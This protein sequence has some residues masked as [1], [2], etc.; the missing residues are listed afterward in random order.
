[1]PPSPLLSRARQTLSQAVVRYSTAAQGSA[2]PHQAAV[3]QGLGQLQSLSAKLESR[4][5]RVAVFGL[6]S[7]GKSAVINAL[8][9]ESILETGPLHGVT[10]WPRSV[11]WQPEVDSDLPWQIELVDTPGL[12]E[13]GGNIRADMA[14]TVANQADL[15]LFVVAGEITQLEYDA[16]AELQ[17][18][19]KPLLLVFNKIDLYP[20]VDRQAVYDTLNSLRTELG[21]DTP[22]AKLA[23]EEVVMVAASPAP[24]QVRVEWPDGRTSDEWE[25]QPPQIEPLRQALLAIVGQDGSALVALNALRHA[26]SI[27]GDMVG[28]VSRLHG[29][30]A[31]ETIWQFAKY[32]A[33]AVALNP[34]A[35]LDLLGGVLIDLVM[36]RTLAR[37]YGFPITGHEAG[38]LWRAILKS[39]GTLLLSELG[40]GLLGAGK[41][42]AALVALVDSASG[43]AAL[44]GAM[45]A[46][47]SAAG[48][49]AYTVGQAAK[50]YLEQGCTWGPEGVS[51]TLA[52]LLNDTQTS[53]T[54]ARLR[55]EVEADLVTVSASNS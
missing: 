30:R 38:R 19:H 20:E 40:S 37:L 9:G 11:Y 55:Q 25:P 51:A 32:K 41:T 42:T 16:L 14:Q 15:I 45:T 29:D 2:N 44:A 49:G 26:R 36:I 35:G 46:Q 18:G 53:A 1:M 7:R 8:V 21:R 12:D 31:N 39:S 27:E 28:H 3:K 54:L 43:I 17:R 22:G 23:V 13:V 24:L 50:T 52:A 6:V 34:I 47:A 10:R 5:L 4:C 33:A 48:Y